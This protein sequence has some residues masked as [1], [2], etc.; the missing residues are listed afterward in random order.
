MTVYGVFNGRFHGATMGY[1]LL[2][3]TT[4]SAM[5]WVVYI[6]KWKKKTHNDYNDCNLEKS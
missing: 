4:D 5:S 1:T 2:P 3:T 6:G